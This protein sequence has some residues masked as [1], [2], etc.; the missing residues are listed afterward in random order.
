MALF[1]TVQRILG[2]WIPDAEVPSSQDG[3][4]KQKFGWPVRSVKFLPEGS[5]GLAGELVWL[6]TS[7][8]LSSWKGAEWLRGS[9]AAR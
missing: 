8:V 2:H 3:M 9:Q 7:K 5:G 1:L 4:D 6:D